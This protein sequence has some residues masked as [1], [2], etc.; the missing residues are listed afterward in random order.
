MSKP[1]R[2]VVF[3]WEGTLGDTLGQIFNSVATEA[4]RL[5]FGE[6]DQQVA[7]Q[8]VD[9]GLVKALRKVFPHLSDA[10]HEQLLYAVQQ[11]LISR[12][13]E[14]YLIPGAKDFV[15]RLQQAGIDVAIASNKGQQSLQRVLHISGLDTLFKV[16]RSAGQTAAKPSPEMLKEILDTFDVTA[17]EALMVGDSVTDMQMAKNLGVDA[18]GVD[19]YHQQKTALLAAGALAV[20][21]DYQHLADYL[22]LPKEGGLR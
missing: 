4:R 10:Q 5:N 20:F 15:G 1:Y 3:D 17:D 21:D 2:L 6:I 9:L 7:R 8:A 22:Q 19:F 18:I 11:S 16:T 13:T 12:S 14:V